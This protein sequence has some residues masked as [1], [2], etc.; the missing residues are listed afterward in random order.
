ML[1][2]ALKLLTAYGLG[3]VMGA[4][5]LGRLIGVDIRTQG[6]G[7][8]GGT[9]ALRTQGVGFAAGVVMIDV[10][11]GWAASHWV[12]ELALPGVSPDSTLPRETLTYGCACAATVGHV[13]PVWWEFRGGKG[14][15]TLIGALLGSVPAVVPV[16]IVVWLLVVVAFGF[17]G[18][19]TVCAVA[20]LPLMA[21]F[22][23]GGSPEFLVF[24]LSMALLVAYTHRANLQRMR[25]RTEPRAR[26][27]WMVTYLR[28]EK[29]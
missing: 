2:L 5:L 18:L 13:Y 9:N 7:N 15:A 20:S 29:A 4:L 26:R 8:A 22:R 24:A 27:L 1:E 11:K 3:S 19:A 28:R 23:S 17:V 10:L 25:S 14:A 21:A 6:S 12:P 16:V